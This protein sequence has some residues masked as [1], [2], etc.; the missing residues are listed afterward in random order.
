MASPAAPIASLPREIRVFISWTFRDMQGER[1]ELVKQI[2]PQLRR[3]CTG[4]RT[5]TCKSPQGT[6]CHE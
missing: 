6:V 5:G 2:F 3:R 4:P 1:E